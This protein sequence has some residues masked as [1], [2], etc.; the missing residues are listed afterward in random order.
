LRIN[1]RRK[2]RKKSSPHPLG[3][4]SKHAN[5]GDEKKDSIKAVIAAAILLL[6]ETKGLSSKK[7]RKARPPPRT[8]LITHTGGKVLVT[9]SELS[10][11]ERPNLGVR[12]R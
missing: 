6:Y 11:G 8:M 7:R 12:S 5:I 10:E 3:Y 2:G 4:S 9:S 1:E